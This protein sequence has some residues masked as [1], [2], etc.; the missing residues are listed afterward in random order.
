MEIMHNNEQKDELIPSAHHHAKPLLAEVFSSLSVQKLICQSEV[1]K[2]NLPCENVKYLFSDW[3]IDVLSLN[4][5]GYLTEFEVKISRSDFKADSKKKK[6]QW[7]E[8]RIENMISNYFYYTCPTG[9]ILDTEIPNFAGLIYVSN[10]GLQV[11]RK[12]PLLHKKK[13][14]KVKVLSKFCRVMSERNSLGSCRMT[15]ENA[16]R[17]SS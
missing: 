12:A 9:L 13:H 2:F 3:E 5:N 16:N 1:L 4:K 6:W 11:I 7:Y 14:D 10:N 15:F 17:M 8:K